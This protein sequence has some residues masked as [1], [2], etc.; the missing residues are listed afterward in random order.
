MNLT[1]PFRSNALVIASATTGI[2]PTVAEFELSGWGEYLQ[3]AGG[4]ACRVT[5]HP[6]ELHPAT[7]RDNYE[8][9]VSNGPW[10]RRQRGLKFKQSIGATGLA[11]TAAGG[12]QHAPRDAL[13]FDP[14]RG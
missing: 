13:A 7:T 11:H 4:N 5:V 3:R 2:H 12:N 8:K 9:V 10:V 14:S 1:A 6:M